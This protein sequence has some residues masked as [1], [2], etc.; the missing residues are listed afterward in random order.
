MKG[1]A[2][3]YTF[4]LGKMFRVEFTVKEVIRKGLWGLPY[5]REGRGLRT[6][7]NEL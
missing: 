4:K 7:L 6:M 2:P 1:E 3:M 5:T